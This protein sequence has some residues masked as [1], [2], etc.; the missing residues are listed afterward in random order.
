MD[1]IEETLL[2]VAPDLVSDAIREPDF[3]AA[4]CPDLEVGASPG[5]VAE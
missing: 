4:R 5:A 3:T 1:L 2:A